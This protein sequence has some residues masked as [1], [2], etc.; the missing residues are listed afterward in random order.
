MSCRYRVVLAVLVSLCLLGGALAQT[1]MRD[2]S[3]GDIAR[4][5]RDKKRPDVQVTASDAKDLFAALDEVLSFA[6]TDTGFLRRASVKRQLVGRDEVDREFADAAADKA[7]QQRLLQ[8]EVVLKKFG[9]L[10]ADFNLQQYLVK[11]LAKEI[12]GYYNSKTKTMYLVN[13]MPLD[14]QRPIMAHELTHALQD[15]N[16]GLLRF[17]KAGPD[18]KEKENIAKLSVNAADNSD[19]VT[20]RRAVVEGQAML[21]YMDYTNKNSGMLVSESPLALSAMLSGL[22][23]YDLP[24][25][26]HDTPRVIEETQFFPYREGLAFEAEVLQKSG[27]EAAFGG[28]FARPPRSTHE[29]LT[30]EAYL[31]EA[32]L[33]VVTIPDLRPILQDAYQPYDSGT[34]GEL[35]VRIMAREFGRENDIFTVAAKWHGGAY[36]VAKRTAGDASAKPTT[37]DLALLY[38]SRWTTLEAAKRFAQIYQQALAKRVKVTQA[39]STGADCPAGA[40]CRQPLWASRLTTDEG[41]AFLEI[42]PGNTLLIAQSFD[43]KTVTQLR[44]AVL[45]SKPSTARRRVPAR[46]LSLSLYA[47]RTFVALQEM[48]AR[49]IVETL[50][51]R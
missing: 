28:V 6:S 27:R 15:Q 2:K 20:V 26:F 22:R 46:E 4:D 18:G 29:V 32:R 5:L 44:Q 35:D 9:L 37:A 41:P 10:P 39:E 38:V 21:V 45:F 30:P 49:R 42:W 47:S 25:V 7:E 11:E 36:V 50:A 33:P 40:N 14:Q 3:L 34:M 17:M 16:Y 48:V 23:D 1:P 43:D 51:A 13:W 8:S 24:V 19:F 31:K 12:G